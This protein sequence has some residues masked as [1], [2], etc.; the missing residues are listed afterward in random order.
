MANLI[1]PV[2]KDQDELIVRNI[3]S[4][5]ISVLYQNESVNRSAQYDA[6]FHIKKWNYHAPD[7]NSELDDEFAF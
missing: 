6:I 5:L 2:S 3:E 1:G 7:T 4:T